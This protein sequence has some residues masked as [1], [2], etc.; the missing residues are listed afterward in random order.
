MRYGVEY[1]LPGGSIG[2]TI[3][4][5]QDDQAARKY[6]EEMKTEYGHTSTFNLKPLPD[7]SIKELYRLFLRL[8]S[9]TSEGRGIKRG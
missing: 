3:F 1:Q 8:A 6:V 4:S 7:C 2:L 5:A 9:V